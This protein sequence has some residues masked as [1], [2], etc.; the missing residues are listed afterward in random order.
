MLMSFP[1]LKFSIY[2]IGYQYTFKLMKHIRDYQSTKEGMGMGFNTLILLA[3]LFS[4]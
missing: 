3:S 1:A 2:N 4:T